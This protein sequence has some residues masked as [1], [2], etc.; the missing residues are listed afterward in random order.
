[1]GTSR[2]HNKLVILAFALVSGAILAQTL[3]LWHRHNVDLLREEYQQRHGPIEVPASLDFAVKA[4]SVLIPV[5][6][7]WI[8]LQLASAIVFCCNWRKFGNS[9]GLAFFVLWLISWGLCLW[10]M[11]TELGFTGNR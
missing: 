7:A 5:F 6:L 2:V 4:A 1:M 3:G 8:L 9:G 10:P 11:F